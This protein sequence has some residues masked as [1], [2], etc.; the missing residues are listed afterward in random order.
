MAVGVR[1]RPR[2]VVDAGRD[3]DGARPVLL[4]RRDE[5]RRR[6]HSDSV[7]RWPVGGRADRGP[8]P[9]RRHGRRD[10]LGR[11]RRARSAG[12]GRAAELR[13]EQA[14]GERDQSDTEQRSHEPDL[15]PQTTITPPRGYLPIVRA[16]AS[17]EARSPASSPSAAGLRYETI[18]TEAAFAALAQWWDP[19]VLSMAR[20]SPFLLHCWLLQWWRHYGGGC[21]LAGPVAY[22]G[23]VLV[24]A[25]PLIVHRRRSLE[26][27]TFL[28]GRQSVLA[29]VLLAPGEDPAVA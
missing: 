15:P 5:L 8:H 27:A 13:R 18:S 9:D 6:S 14:A 11:S 21:R 10:R 29:D 25:L 12:L 23:P 22:R 28:G 17:P 2:A 3:D 19:L 26:V 7:P 1:E 16:G 20:P 24:G 4:E